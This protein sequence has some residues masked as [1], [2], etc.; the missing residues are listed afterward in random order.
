[1]A[2]GLFRRRRREAAGEAPATAPEPAS[3]VAEADAGWHAVRPLTTTVQRLS[4][5][6]DGLR[7]RDGLAAWQDPSQRIELGHAVSPE[8]PVGLATGLVRSTGRAAH[9][10]RPGLPRPLVHRVPPEP[11]AAGQ[12]ETAM[13]GTAPVPISRRA[14]TGNPSVVAG[15]DT[16]PSAESF[17]DTL[18]RPAGPAVPSIPRGRLTVARAVAPPRR[19]P[20]AA[21]RPAR[22]PVVADRPPL[23][24]WTTAEHGAPSVLSEPT[25]PVG[26]GPAPE[27]PVATGP[28]ADPSAGTAAPADPAPARES[29]TS[30]SS[31][32]AEHASIQR[33][34]TASGSP[35]QSSPEARENPVIQRSTSDS[36]AASGG[37]RSSRSAPGIGAPLPALPSTARFVTGDRSP[38]EPAAPS[39]PLLPDAEAIQ[40][41][42]DGN[43]AAAGLQA[44]T[45]PPAPERASLPVVSGD[46][47][48]PTDPVSAPPPPARESTAP[49]TTSVQRASDQSTVEGRRRPALGEPMSALPPSAG[50]PHREPRAGTRRAPQE[51]PATGDR[52]LLPESTSI[53]RLAAKSGSDRTDRATDAPAAA[54]SGALPVVAGQRDE[55]ADATSAAPASSGRPSAASGVTAPVPVEPGHRG[56]PPATGAGD[57]PV[58]IARAAV[59]AVRLRGLLPERPLVPE[60]GQVGGAEPATAIGP[61]PIAADRPKVVAAKWGADAEE[62]VQSATTGSAWS[63]AAQPGARGSSPS[64]AGRSPASGRIGSGSP[65]TVRSGASGSGRSG[66]GEVA[67]PATSSRRSTSDGAR[68]V[69]RVVAASP[70][71]AG[72]RQGSAANLPA[73]PPN[74]PSRQGAILADGP[75]P[76][77]PVPARPPVVA[78]AAAKARPDAPPVPVRWTPPAAAAVSVQRNP[79]S[80]G[81]GAGTNSVAA[82]VPV[83]IPVTT[84]V[85]KEPDEE[86]KS[87]GGE[88]ADKQPEPEAQARQ[89]V[90]AVTRLLRA[91]LR[92][93]RERSGRLHERRR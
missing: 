7:F 19:L 87:G 50:T 44:A 53:Q 60:F 3:P 48:T 43:P 90:D 8:A 22:A 30:A 63:G 78:A 66:A 83:D 72:P 80:S 42:I 33:S 65:G 49:E 35:R 28:A 34:A 62:P 27:L 18:G 6:S 73:S 74:W 85:K 82:D 55:H 64:G 5:M 79:S 39:R 32:P 67:R 52:P 1:M 4:T 36:A 38:H 77:G 46:R 13:E 89:I 21:P 16:A 76:A 45:P 88:T 56:A 29:G 93:G 25:A 47:D 54:G 26:P 75:A 86:K 84:T 40:R 57:G 14:S 17:V 2:R 23:G 69:Q 68:P 9:S 41:L 11:E 12:P 81:G 24:T 15:R 59:A 31:A 58:M 61:R 20:L 51:Q 91:E 70:G 71:A 92:F 37:T 10:P